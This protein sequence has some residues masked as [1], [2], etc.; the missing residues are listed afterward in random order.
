[1]SQTWNGYR[2]HRLAGAQLTTAVIVGLNVVVWLAV[3][4][5][6]SN[7]GPVIRA[8]GL[9]PLG[10][11]LSL[12]SPGR[13]APGVGEAA[14]SGLSGM[15]WSPGVATGAYWQ[16]L[17]SAFTHAQVWHIAFNMLAVALLGPTMERAIGRSRFIALYLTSALTSAAAIMWFA[18]PAS[19]TI[20]A[21][22]AV[23]GL[24]G[25]LLIVAW[26]RHGDV[27]GVMVWLGLN[28]AF[29]L[30]NSGVSWQGHLGGLAG[31]LIVG[32][33]LVASRR[34]RSPAAWLGIAGLVLVT[35]VLIVVRARVLLG[36]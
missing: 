26:R 16:L 10:T 34:Q 30:L 21:S 5:T 28:V 4:V 19:A 6:G 24:M 22:G 11:C 29:T 36:T 3:L 14:C 7:S 1:V 32:G 31:G 12:A 9:T 35:L 8:F 25:A 17:T 33:L 20:G 23:F 13:Y 15:A 27:R 2:L 18:A